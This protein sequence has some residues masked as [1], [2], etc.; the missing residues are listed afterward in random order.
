MAFKRADVLNKP[1]L[2]DSATAA[3]VTIGMGFD[4]L[5]STFEPNIEDTLWAASCEGINGGDARILG[6][7]VD[8]IAVHG[9][10][11]NVDRLTRLANLEPSIRV[12]AFWAAVAQWRSKDAR[13]ARLRRLYTQ[14][15]MDYLPV[16]TSFGIERHGEDPRFVCTALRVPR[17]VLRERAHHITLP[18]QLAR[19][20][21]GYRY[22]ILMGPSYRADMWALLDRWPH[23]S[24]AE[25]ARRAYGSH[26]TA[27]EVRRD[28]AL[29]SLAPL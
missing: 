21:R 26:G 24:C 27:R 17:G 22:R 12:Q 19:Q 15:P 8:W 7:L 25:L 6:L 5:P 28:W 13:F 4:S 16:G 3:Y 2:G 20:H 9:R 10:R 1:L 29:L 23:L 14:A 18:E 11:I